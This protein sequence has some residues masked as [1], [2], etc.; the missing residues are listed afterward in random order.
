MRPK[1]CLRAV[2]TAGLLFLPVL[3]RAQS[4]SGEKNNSSVL[5][6]DLPVVETA[7]LHSQTLAEAPAS[8]T[9]ITAA[10][11]R[12]YG[13]R[14]LGEALSNVRGFY[15]SYDRE[16][17]SVGVRG[18]SLPGDYNTRF[19]V[20][21]NGHP[22]TENIYGSNNFFGYDFGLDMELVKRI[23]IVR[24]PSSA[25]YGT[26]GIFAT[27]NVITTTAADEPAARAG[28]EF[29]SLGERKVSVAMSRYL[30]GAANLL[31]SASVFNNAG[32]SLYFPEFDSADTNRGVARGADG[33]KGYHGFLNLTWR[34]W[35]FTG[36]FNARQKHLP[37]APYGT[38]FNDRGTADVDRRNFVEAAY[39]RDLG[40]QSHLRV[41]F[42]YDQYRFAGRYDYAREGS[43]AGEAGGAIEDNR[44][45]GAGDWVGAQVVYRR[46]LS[47][48]GALT[49][50]MEFKSDIRA[51]QTNYDVSPLRQTFLDLNNPVTSAAVF[52]Q[53]E[54]RLGSHVTISL[55]ARLD[56]TWGYRSVL[57]PRL[58]LIYQASAGTVVK[59]LYGEAFRN[60]NA[61]ELH[62]DDH[63]LS[64]RANPALLPEKARTL[65]VDLEHRIS[66][67]LNAIA[68]VYHYALRDLIQAVGDDDGVVQ[69]R[70]ASRASAA[71][72]ESELN[73]RVWRSLETAAGLTVQR[74]TDQSG[75]R[76]ANSPARIAHF[77]VS[78]A[79]A[80]NRLEWSG[81]TRYLSSRDTRGT[82]RVPNVWVVDVT[83]STVHLRRDFDLR[84][85]V[86][87]LLDRR[88]W[89]P[90]AYSNSMDRIAADGR[91][92]FLG[93]FWHGGQ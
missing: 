69:Y 80:R 92:V 8:V 10:D 64:Q 21:I 23:E 41:R 27:I 38:L 33:E 24:G 85:G 66:K 56:K 81:S 1:P 28:V 90:T 11:I 78:S 37:A 47:H 49:A 61:F 75:R 84:A 57:D 68:G 74:V 73:G 86:R 20:M 50:G 3:V 88:N 70:N 91:S 13:Y 30:G 4:R 67:R 29:D 42:Y 79:L 34:N 14:T 54:Q 82:A 53:Y 87:N 55:G 89:D 15:Q 83:V 19:L 44:D 9:I 12:R 63:G 32:Q 58:A 51:V 36:Y 76:L 59:A 31:V 72:I 52:G 43:G 71:G 40:A 46:E 62:Y 60:P 5:F 26:N 35:S 22:L 18:F 2:F 17:H 6:E 93:I 45:L 77:R 65:E 48:A 7:S 25:L 16:Y 39:A